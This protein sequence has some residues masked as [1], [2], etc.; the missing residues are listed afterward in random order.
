MADPLGRVA[1]AATSRTPNTADVVLASRASTMSGTRSGP[2]AISVKRSLPP[3]D[4]AAAEQSRPPQ[5][6]TPDGSVIASSKSSAHAYTRRVPP[7]S[8]AFSTARRSVLTG[9]S[10]V[11]SLASSPRRATNTPH[12]SFAG[13]VAGS[14][15]HGDAGKTGGVS[16]GSGWHVNVLAQ[17]SA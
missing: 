12:P 17:S 5:I 7:G 16:P 15:S 1:S 10:L 11:P 3:Q 13:L 9:A 4:H 2:G 14:P 6:A 8:D